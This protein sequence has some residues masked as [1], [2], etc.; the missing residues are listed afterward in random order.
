MDGK[1]EKPLAES[2][3]N[4]SNFYDFHLDRS[5]VLEKICDNYM[6]LLFGG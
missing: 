3:W 4:S 5:S 1:T 6:G 2:V